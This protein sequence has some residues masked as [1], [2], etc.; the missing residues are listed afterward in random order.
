M[1]LMCLAYLGLSFLFYR[2]DD[3]RVEYSKL[4]QIRSILN[5]NVRVMALTATAIKSLRKEILASLGMKD[6]VVI[7]RSPD[8]PNIRYFVRRAN[9]MTIVKV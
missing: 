8:K 7:S 9:I 2:G 3:F 1:T 6:S 4:Q 5:P